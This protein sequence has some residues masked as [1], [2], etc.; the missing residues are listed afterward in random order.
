MILYYKI[1]SNLFT[2]HL[3]FFSLQFELSVKKCYVQL[4]KHKNRSLCLFHSCFPCSFTNT[5][6][7]SHLR[8]DYKCICKMGIASEPEVSENCILFNGQ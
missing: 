2:V 3:D 5:D 4:S 7:I 8:V 6:I 1:H